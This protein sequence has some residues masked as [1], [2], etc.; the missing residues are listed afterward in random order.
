MKNLIRIAWE[1]FLAWVFDNSH[2]QTHMRRCVDS[3]IKSVEKANNLDTMNASVSDN[4]TSKNLLLPTL[5]L[6]SLFLFGCGTLTDERG[7]EIMKSH[8]LGRDLML[9]EKFE[10]EYANPITVN[11]HTNL[12]AIPSWII[13]SGIPLC[14]VKSIKAEREIGAKSNV[15]PAAA[16]IAELGKATAAFSPF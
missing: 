15:G 11:I 16:G 2:A 13:R 14:N 3:A 9:H 12:Q 1:N 4:H 6:V 8:G 7:E 5:L 10:V